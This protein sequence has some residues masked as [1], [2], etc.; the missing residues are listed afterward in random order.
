VISFNS[1]TTSILTALRA[2]GAGGCFFSGDAQAALA[3]HVRR[4]STS[5]LSA[6]ERQVLGILADGGT[7]RSAATDL[8]LTRNTVRTYLDR[9]YDKLGVHSAEAAI[10]AAFRAGALR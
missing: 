8:Y 6:R 2:V 4:E 7:V 1:P 9:A 10:A 5:I 3:G